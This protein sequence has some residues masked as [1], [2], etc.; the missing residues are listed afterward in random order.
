MYLENDKVSRI[1]QFRKYLK[2]GKIIQYFVFR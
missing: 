2:F 1:Q